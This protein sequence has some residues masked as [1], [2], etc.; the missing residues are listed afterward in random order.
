MSLYPIPVSR[1]VLNAHPAE[2][3]SRAV[4]AEARSPQDALGLLAALDAGL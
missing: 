1:E 3:A 4:I 2:R